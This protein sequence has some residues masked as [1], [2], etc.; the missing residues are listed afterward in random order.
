MT[1]GDD[2]DHRG[3]EENGEF[4]RAVGHAIYCWHTDPAG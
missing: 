3:R 2:Y 4:F 1:T